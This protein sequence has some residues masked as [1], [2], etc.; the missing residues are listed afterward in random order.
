MDLKVLI[1]DFST[2]VG[3]DGQTWKNVIGWNSLHSGEERVDL[4]TDH[5]LMVS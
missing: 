2:L 5:H 4:S 1:G 3:K